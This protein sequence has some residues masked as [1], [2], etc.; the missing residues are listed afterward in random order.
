MGLVPIAGQPR[1]DEPGRGEAAGS[2]G[3][4][5]DV[6]TG[7]ID[8]ALVRP[9]AAAPQQHRVDRV[10]ERGP[11]RDED[12]PH[13]PKAKDDTSGIPRRFSPHDA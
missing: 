11:Q 9:V 6:A 2:R 10:H 1:T 4:V 3:Q 12:Q 5:D 8:R 13:R 7:V